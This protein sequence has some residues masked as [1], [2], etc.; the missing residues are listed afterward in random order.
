MEPQEVTDVELAFGGR[1][2]ELLP[3]YEDLPEEFQRFKT[4]WNRIISKWFFD[5]LPKNTNFIAKD[6]INAEKALRHIAAVL[7]SFEPKHEHKEAGCAY[8]L[9]L[10][11]KEVKLPNVDKDYF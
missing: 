11:F 7:R 2:K 8:L 1:I 10:W 5:G 9:S 3:P 6:G 4:D